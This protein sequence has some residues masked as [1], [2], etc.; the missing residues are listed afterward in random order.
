MK[1][2]SSLTIAVLPLYLSLERVQLTYAYS[3]LW[4]SLPWS[5]CRKRNLVDACV[6]AT[7]VLKPI[8]RFL[9]INKVAY[10]YRA[11]SSSMVRLFSMGQGLLNQT[12]PPLS[13]A[14]LLQFL[15][16]KTKQSFSTTGSLDL[17]LVVLHD[18][19]RRHLF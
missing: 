9:T 7:K 5:N 3:P 6:R 2:N 11:F 10:H 17:P 19:A 12:F 8:P 15:V 4:L 16:L 13:A 18:Q 14:K 1:Q